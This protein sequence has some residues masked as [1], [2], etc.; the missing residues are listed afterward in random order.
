M[1]N[2]IYQL[3][4]IFYFIVQSYSTEP[5]LEHGQAIK[6]EEELN[7]MLVWETMKTSMCHLPE[8]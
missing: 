6:K 2:K 7:C 4:A 8:Q 3:S 1:K 5:L